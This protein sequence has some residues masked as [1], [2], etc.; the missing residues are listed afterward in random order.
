MPTARNVLLI[1]SDQQHWRSMGCYDR[2][3]R[4]P[5]LDRMAAEGLRADR[6]YCP[7]PTCTPSRASIITGLMPSQHGAYSL[8]THLDPAVPTI[9]ERLHAAGMRTALVGKAHFQGTTT[10]PRWPSVESYPLLQDLDYWRRFRGPWYG[11]DEVELLRNHTDEPHVGQHYG[12]W[13]EER[14]PGWRRYFQPPEARGRGSHRAH[15]WDLPEELHY[16]R[17]IEERTIARLE[18]CARAG[19][20]FFTW[21]SFPDPHPSYLTSGRWADLYRPEDMAIPPV[22][23]DEHRHWPPYL[24]KTREEQ[25]SYD[26]FREPEGNALHRCHSHRV[27]PAVLRRNLATYHGMMAFVDDC[28]G[29][30]LRALDRLGLAED[31]LVVF[32]TDHGHFL[33]EHGLTHKGPFH[34]EDL[35]RVPFLVRQPGAVPAGTVSDALVS[36]VDL[37]PTMLSALG[38]EADRRMSG[39]DQWEVWT[40]RRPSVRDH[41]L[42]ENRHQPHALHLDT[43]VDAR[44]KLTVQRGHEWGE[45]YDLAG[46]PGET[47]NRWDDPAYALRK[48]ELLLRMVHAEMAKAPVPM[49]R[50]SGA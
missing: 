46:D 5:N 49:P 1:T 47:R 4:T 14:C 25:P 48:S 50:I 27:D 28:V 18:T 32:S 12:I 37:A 41:V 3:F 24:A 2:R 29:G 33:G 43:Y 21:A 19:E 26:E 6:A 45:L 13:L 11:F 7:N 23:P 20:R 39:V 15:R 9:G 42:V 31:T 34:F 8:G 16:N 10:H 17:W 22:D 40:G 38:L 30:I 35:V 36:L 44:W